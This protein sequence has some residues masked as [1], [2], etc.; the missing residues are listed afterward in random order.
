M[1][2]S[3]WMKRNTKTT[4][5][6][7]LQKETDAHI[8]II[9]GGLTGITTAYYLAQAE[10]D[11]ILLEADSLC[12]GA[13]GRNTGKLTMQ[14]GLL[15]A[16]LIEH[17]DR[18]LAR[19]YYEA[20]EEAL[21]SIEAIIQEH[22]IACSFER[23]DSML[24]TRDAVQVAKLQ[25]EY[26]AYL[27]L[28]I[29]CTYIEKN[30][31]PFPMEAGLRMQYQARFDPYAYGCALAEIAREGG[32]DIYEHSPVTDMQ[33]EEQG[34]R[35][36]VNGTCVHADIVIFAMQFPFI[37]QG[38]FYFTRMYCDQE[39]IISA[40]VKNPL[41]KDMMLSI[42]DRV[43]S[44]NTCEDTLLY[45]GNTYKSGQDKAMN[46]QEFENTLREDF[47]VQ[48]IT[49]AWSSQ[50]YMTFDQLPLIGKLDKHE[51]R[52]L[53]ASGYN[54]WGNTTSCIAGK[55]LCSY[56]LH[57]GSPYRMMFSPQRLSSIFSL[58]FVK[59]NLN[60]VGA[61]LKSK[62]QKSTTAY[63][64]IGEGT[65]MELD[66]HRYGV[67]RDENDELYI[68]DILC[69]HL[70][71]TLRFNADEKTWDCPCHGSR[72]SYTGEIIKGPATQRLHT[73]HE[74]HNS[75][76]PHIVNPDTADH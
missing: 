63:P 76:D 27:D 50:D 4:N 54:K 14:H 46:L 3:F 36:I 5:Y 64:H 35:L 62:L 17:Y 45:A 44:Y 10:E 74:P 22:H 7:T 11:A 28:H 56:A 72:F 67:Y 58:Q 68:V 12:F 1:T 71:C 49:S 53:F 37:D 25:E 16:N 51:D 26:Q 6:P 40:R 48:E 59:E 60:V 65:I 57:R 24:F 41:P 2:E 19:Q 29:P 73:M 61:F 34:Y 23:C 15:Y 20:N 32:I 70:G 33:E 52:V 39:S 21:N 38:H 9:G 13:S 55:L 66:D 47:I 75:I 43:Q 42:D 18:I 30:D 31:A 69:P 8:A